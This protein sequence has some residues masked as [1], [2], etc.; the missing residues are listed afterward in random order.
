MVLSLDGDHPVE[1]V[2]MIRQR[3]AETGISH[4][5]PIRYCQSLDVSL[6]RMLAQQ[7]REGKVQLKF[8]EAMLDCNLPRRGDAD[9]NG[10]L[11][12]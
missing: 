10:T 3:K 2:S 8:P 5:I 6:M 1:G 12:R 4:D 7:F 9:I 11:L